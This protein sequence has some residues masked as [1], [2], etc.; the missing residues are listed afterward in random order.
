MCKSIG[1]RA[2][3][4]ITTP[5]AWDLFDSQRCARLVAVISVFL[6]SLDGNELIGIRQ[7]NASK[8]LIHG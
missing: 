6:L 5:L 2:V 3:C 1:L 7:T 4:D 8:T